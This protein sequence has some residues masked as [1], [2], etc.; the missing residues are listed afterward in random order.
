MTHLEDERLGT[1]DRGQSLSD[2][3]GNLGQ[4]VDLFD[5]SAFSHRRAHLVNRDS[6]GEFPL[7][8]TSITRPSHFETAW[9]LV[10]SLGVLSGR[11]VSSRR[12]ISRSGCDD[13]RE[14]GRRV[15][16]CLSNSQ[17]WDGILGRNVDCA[18]IDLCSS[19]FRA[20]GTVC[21]LSLASEAFRCVD[22]RSSR[23]PSGWPVLCRACY[24]RCLHQW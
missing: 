22:S 11:D 10:S 16:R 15:D 12:D 1:R 21:I 20:L 4:H 19:R 5:Q 9:S 14:S 13:L 18:Q 2:D 23:A 8:I 24:P 7:G 17:D 6:C 3:I